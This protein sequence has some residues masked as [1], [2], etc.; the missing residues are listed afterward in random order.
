MTRL[1][2]S[3]LDIRCRFFMLFRI[4][5][6][7]RICS[8]CLLI[9]LSILVAKI[10]MLCVKTCR[11]HKKLNT[12]MKIMVNVRLFQGFMWRNGKLITHTLFISPLNRY[13]ST[14]IIKNRES[15]NLF[16]E[17]V[18]KS[19]NLCR[20]TLLK[21]IIYRNVTFCYDIEQLT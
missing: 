3:C 17:N 10:M 6:I 5:S 8:T 13:D 21:Y 19:P 11:D 2:S 1:R 7:L 14:E 15:P 20:K 4:S 9:S 12:K 16:P 18:G